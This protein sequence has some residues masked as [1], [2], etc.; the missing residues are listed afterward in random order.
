[1]SKHG[2]I[3]GFGPEL[4]MS[5]V[6]LRRG[7]DDTQDLNVRRVI[8]SFEDKGGVVLERTEENDGDLLHGGIIRDMVASEWQER[9]FA[10]IRLPV[11]LGLGLMA[12][13]QGRGS[14]DVATGLIADSVLTDEQRQRVERIDEIEQRFARVG[15][16][17][18]KPAPLSLLRIWLR[19][20][21]YWRGDTREE[22][23][24]TAEAVA[25]N[26]W[27]EYRENKDADRPVADVYQGLVGALRGVAESMVGPTHAGVV[28]SIRVTNYLAFPGTTVARAGKVIVAVATTLGTGMIDGVSMYGTGIHEMI[29]NMDVA[30]MGGDSHKNSMMASLVLPNRCE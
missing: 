29:H 6:R 11:L 7:G 10:A 26:D 20:D 18:Y 23:I 16:V 8:E 19:D 14:D 17:A 21:A 22:A 27:W 28:C 4:G 9:R 13:G 5:G 30:Q 25:P 24:A 15:I 3:M 12:C 2:E 1:M